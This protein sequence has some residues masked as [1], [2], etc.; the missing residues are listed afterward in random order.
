MLDLVF[1]F[2]PTLAVAMVTNTILGIYY[3]VGIKNSRFNWKIL[4]TGIIKALIIAISFM[5]LGF[6]FDQINLSSIGITPETIMNA[7][8]ILYVSKSCIKL[9]KILGIEN[10][11]KK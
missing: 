6:C 1:K 11:S 5:G 8:I 9:S 2:I 10:T 4:L 7:A 3:N